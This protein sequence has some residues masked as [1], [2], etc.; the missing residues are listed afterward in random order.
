[1]KIPLFSSSRYLNYLDISKILFERNLVCLKYSSAFLPYER[2]LHS[3]N[4]NL[5]TLIIMHSPAAVYHNNRI[6]M[7][8]LTDFLKTRPKN[9]HFSMPPERRPVLPFRSPK[10]ASS[11]QCPVS[12]L[13]VVRRWGVCLVKS[14]HFPFCGPVLHSLCCVLVLLTY[15]C[16]QRLNLALCWT[17]TAVIAVG[18]QLWYNSSHEPIQSLSKSKGWWL[19]CTDLFHSKLILYI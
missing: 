14:H 6:T 13:M 17:F 1:M 19:Y 9:F 10:C 16:L 4:N 7:H 11:L 3:C 5:N 12:L 15:T 2:T 18:K 8:L